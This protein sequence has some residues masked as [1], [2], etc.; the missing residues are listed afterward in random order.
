MTLRVD[1]PARVKLEELKEIGIDPEKSSQSDELEPIVIREHEEIAI[2]VSATGAV[3][4]VVYCLLVE[5]LEDRDVVGEEETVQEA[6]SIS[7]GCTG[8]CALVTSRV[9]VR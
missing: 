3:R 8:K 9:Q 7:R 5:V 6:E 1:V 2:N 4:Q